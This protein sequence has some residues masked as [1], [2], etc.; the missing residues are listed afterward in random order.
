MNTYIVLA[1]AWVLLCLSI[2]LY[3]NGIGLQDK[4]H[5]K[6]GFVA[7]AITYFIGIS[8]LIGIIIYC[9]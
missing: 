6:I 2:G 9:S 5:Y 4:L 8:L 3:I 1:I 7:I